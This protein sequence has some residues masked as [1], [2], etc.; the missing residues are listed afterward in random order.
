MYIDNNL[1]RSICCDKYRLVAPNESSIFEFS[2]A[3]NNGIA[4]FDVE[5]TILPVGSY[6]NVHPNFGGL[7]GGNNFQETRGLIIGSD[8]NTTQVS[9]AWLNYKLN[10]QNYQSIFNREID[11][12]EYMQRY[13][14]AESGLNAIIGSASAGIGTTIATANPVLGIG[15]GITSLGA[16]IADQ[17]I[18]QNKFR[19][20]LNFKRDIFNLQLGNIKARPNT[21]ARSTN[22]TLD[23]IMFPYIEYYTCTEFEKEQ[24]DQQI[25]YNGMTINAFGKFSDYVNN[26]DNWTYLQGIIIELNE[27][28]DDSHIAYHINEQL[29]RGLKYVNTTIN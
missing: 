19:E 14:M 28:N 29:Q 26:A 11:N 22:I 4:W 9:D 17:F 10:N 13:N 3:R 18:Q 1:K 23:T 15:A 21:L 25:K 8:I 5:G 2:P 20:N 27:L 12:L 16:G 6:I 7:Y 24:F